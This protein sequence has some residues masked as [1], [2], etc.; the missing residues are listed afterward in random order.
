MTPF[1]ANY[2]YH[3]PMQF[4]PPKT[5]SNKMSELLVDATV[6][7]MEQTL[8][9]LW[10]SLLE[11]QARQSKCAGRKDLNFKARNTVWL[12]TQYFSTSRPPQDL[13]DKRTGPYTVSNINNKNAYKLNL[14]KTMRNHN[15][16]HVS[17]FNHY[18]PP[19]VGQPSSQPHPDIVDDSKQ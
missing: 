8:L 17:Q 4:K 11:A 2:H 16:F 7:G 5:S 3:P 15:V 14:P 10:E 9:L 19:V 1:W 18:T 6:S 12:S 13:N